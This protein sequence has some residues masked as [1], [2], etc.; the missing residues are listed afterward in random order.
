[1]LRLP[2]GNVHRIRR[3]QHGRVHPLQVRG[4]HDPLRWRGMLGLGPCGDFA[5]YSR[6]GFSCWGRRVDV[7][8][9][10]HEACYLPSASVLHVF[11]FSVTR[12]VV[13]RMFT[14]LF[15]GAEHGV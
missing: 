14:R 13:G 3:L 1:M 4:M 9:D 7:Y 8:V 2:N 10:G 5:V 11:Y 12:I 6:R 15:T